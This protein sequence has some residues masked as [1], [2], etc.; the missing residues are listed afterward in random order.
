[1][2]DAGETDPYDDEVYLVLLERVSF[3]TVE[4]FVFCV[5]LLSFHVLACVCVV[6]KD[7]MMID[8]MKPVLGE[9]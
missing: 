5:L 4:P 8:M 7:G 3:F 1:M 6:K 9:R 2:A